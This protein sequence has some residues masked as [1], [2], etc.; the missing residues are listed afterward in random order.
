MSKKNLI[1]AIVLVLVVLAVAAGV[2]FK[3]S[4]DSEY[5]VVY[6]STGEV[7][8]GKLYTFPSLTLRDIYILQVIPDKTDSTK[9]TF[10]LNPIKDA[11]WA[12]DKL[13]LSRESVVFYGPLL[14]DSKIAQTLAAQEKN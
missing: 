14:S 2:Y 6:L 12:T 9:N 10:Q 13:T 4:K 7:Y 1:I 3:I 8:I 5:S 11:L